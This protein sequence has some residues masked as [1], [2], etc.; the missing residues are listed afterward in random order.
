L[1]DLNQLFQN[2]SIEELLSELNP[3]KH[4]T[5]Y[6]LICPFCEKKEAYIPNKGELKPIIICNR[7]NKCGQI[8]SIWNYLKQFK[9]LTNKE[10]FK[11]LNAKEENYTIP[12]TKKST[13]IKIKIIQKPLKIP[14][15][16]KKYDLNNLIKDFKKLDLELKFQT[17]LTYIYYYS[18]STDQY[19]KELYYKKR[20]IPSPKNIGHLTKKDSYELSE[21]LL[22]LF[23]EK[24]LFR[25]GVFFKGKF[26]F[27]FS[28]FNVIPSFDIY[29]N[30]ITALRFRNN[31]PFKPKELELSYQRFLN[32]LPYP[33]TL[34]KLKK[35]DTFYFTE[36]HI[37]ALSLKIPNVVGVEGTGSFKE[38]NFQ[39]FQNKTII[40]AFD[41]DKA[42]FEGSVK[43]AKK[44]QKHNVKTKFL[45]WNPK[46]GKDIN[47]LLINGYLNKT[48]ISDNLDFISS[49]NE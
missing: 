36:G 9:G 37:D 27:I 47:E 10:I 5:Y 30:L 40:I 15:Y 39:F 23:D 19:F 31:L 6:H 3:T 17:I 1:N 13:K 25:F 16:Q 18:L 44:A 7:K 12:Q 35:F 34:E 46:Y 28:H 48:Y 43:L 32:P 26:K 4:S 22:K 2:I 45:N 11:L 29:T 21:N 42:G 33:L 20:K 14:Q 41:K 49:K 24:S 38:I 8:I